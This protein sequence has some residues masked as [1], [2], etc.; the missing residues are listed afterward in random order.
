MLLGAAALWPI[1]RPSLVMP[2]PALP[3]LADPAAVTMAAA[4][5]ATAP[6]STRRLPRDPAAARPLSAQSAARQRLGLGWVTWRQHRAAL[7][8][9]LVP[10]G[11]LAAVLAYAYPRIQPAYQAMVQ[12][13]CFARPSGNCRGW[14]G[15]FSSYPAPAVTG[16]MSVIV[17]LMAMCLGAPA[18]ARELEWGTHRLSWTQGTGWAVSRM[19]LLSAAVTA[20]TLPLVLLAGW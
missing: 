4:A 7:G 18:V 11:I 6:A 12:A 14:L 3:F 17:V 19:A 5:A 1:R 9:P 16:T 20:I 2:V 15:V 13:H 8:W 10:A